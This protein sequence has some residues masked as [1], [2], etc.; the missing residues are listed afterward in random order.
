MSIDNKAGRNSFMLLI[1]AGCDDTHRGV[2]RGGEKGDRVHRAQ[3][4]GGARDRLLAIGNT[5]TFHSN[6]SPNA[7][8]KKTSPILGTVFK[9]QHM[10][11][12]IKQILQKRKAALPDA[13]AS[14]AS[15]QCGISLL[16]SAALL[17]RFIRDKQRKIIDP[18]RFDRKLLYSR[19]IQAA[20]WGTV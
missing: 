19:V 18:F 2:A 11:N 13:S 17:P 7:E 14:R 1:G 12:R 16:Q 6:S 9:L 4:S 20:G 15:K 8:T 10:R 3:G 5:G